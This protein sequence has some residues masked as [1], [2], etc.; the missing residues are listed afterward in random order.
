M[1]VD[2]VERRL[3]AILSADVVR[4]DPPYGQTVKTMGLD[5]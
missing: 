5:D 3:S 2:R 1:P 4:S